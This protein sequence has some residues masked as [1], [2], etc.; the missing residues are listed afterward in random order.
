MAREQAIAA[1]LVGYKKL[2]EAR[3]K[4]APVTPDR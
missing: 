2:L 4:D 3:L 1:I